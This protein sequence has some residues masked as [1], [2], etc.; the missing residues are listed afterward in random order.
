MNGTTTNTVKIGLI[1]AI[2]LAVLMGMIFAI[3]QHEQPFWES[4]TRYE[5]RLARSGGLQTGAF[6]T[7]DGVQVGTVSDVHLPLDLDAKFIQ[8][9]IKV[10][11]QNAPRV[12]ENSIATVKTIG[13]LGDK[14]VFIKSGTEEAEPIPPL[15]IIPS[16]DS[17][18][19][20]AVVG[21]ILVSLRAVANKVDHGEGT[22]AKLLND[23]SLYN[24]VDGVATSVRAVA[25]KVNNGDGTIGKLVNDPAIHDNLRDITN[26]VNK[27][28]GTLSKLLNDPTIHKNLKDITDKINHGDGTLGLLLNDR[29]LYDNATGATDTIH[30]SR[31]LNL[32]GLKSKDKDKEKKGKDDKK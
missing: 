19:Y 20:E 25:D 5:I 4:Q 15:G 14:Y 26:K 12:R 28:D 1:V 30:R 7:I 6:V 21:D 16:E 3:S 17:T 22:V 9:F 31:L 32:F 23:P 24:S 2:A 10:P 18:D 13:L 27:G 8:V 29:T 11:S